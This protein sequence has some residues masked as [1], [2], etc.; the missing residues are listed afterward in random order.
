VGCILQL[1]LSIHNLQNR[2]FSRFLALVKRRSTLFHQLYLV[3]LQ[4]PFWTIGK[5]FP[6]V[7]SILAK[8]GRVTETNE[9]GWL[10]IDFLV[11][12]KTGSEWVWF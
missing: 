8:R 12:S 6:N 11:R 2:S 5:D 10:S 7:L 1:V 3:W 4:T 9:N